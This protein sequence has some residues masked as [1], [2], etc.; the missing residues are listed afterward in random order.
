MILKDSTNQKW[1]KTKG[2]QQVKKRPVI[3]RVLLLGF[4]AALIFAGV[5]ASNNLKTKGYTGLWDF[6]TS[7]SRNYWNGRNANP[8]Q[9]SIEIKGKDIKILEKNREQALERGLIINDMDGEYVPATLR[10]KGEKLKVKLR[11]KGHMTD[12]LQDNKWSFRIK[13]SDKNNFMGMKRF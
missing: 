6:L 10:Y 13:V 3:K 2:T 7:V 11:L 4:F 5:V 1:R 12:H 8:E 9:V